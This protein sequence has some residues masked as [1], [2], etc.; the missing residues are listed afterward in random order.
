MTTAYNISPVIGTTTASL[1]SATEIISVTQFKIATSA[2]LVI[3][4][5]VTAAIA[6]LS[7]ETV[8]PKSFTGFTTLTIAISDITVTTAS[9][10][11]LT[12]TISSYTYF[13][14]ATCAISVISALSAIYAI[15]AI[16]HERSK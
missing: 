10:A 1:T 15:S 9:L 7:L 12:A 16:R 8:I 2:I 13:T 6:Y 5:S 11:L 14:T 3:S 4:T